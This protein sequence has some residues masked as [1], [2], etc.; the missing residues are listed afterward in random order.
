MNNRNN[1]RELEKLKLH[2]IS[3][4]GVL[5]DGEVSKAYFPGEKSPF[6]VFPMHA[7]MISVLEKGEV[8]YVVKE[9]GEKSIKI[10]G[11]FVEIKDDNIVACVREY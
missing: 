7:P 6:A 2:I 10:Y 1:S 5:F 8:R 9:G 3:P 11:G 4:K